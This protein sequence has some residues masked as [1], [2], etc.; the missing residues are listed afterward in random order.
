VTQDTL[1]DAF[2]MSAELR[3]WL[4]S[5]VLKMLPLLERPGA[6]MTLWP[7]MMKRRKEAKRRIQLAKLFERKGASIVR[8]SR[9]VEAVRAMY[10]EAY[11][12]M[13]QASGESSEHV[14]SADEGR[15]LVE[16]ANRMTLGEVEDKVSSLLEKIDEL[17]H[18]AGFNEGGLDTLSREADMLLQNVSSWRDLF[19]KYV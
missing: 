14:A 13:Q 10:A 5:G 1:I 9:Q 16:I 2:V 12:T 7:Y 19:R 17:K 15:R 6:Y 8:V 11:K 18:E 3:D 4:P